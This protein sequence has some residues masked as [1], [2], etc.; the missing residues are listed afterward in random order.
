MI[1][2]VIVPLAICVKA[3][4]DVNAKKLLRERII[5]IMIL[6]LIVAIIATLIVG[7][8]VKTFFGD[9]CGFVAGIYVCILLKKWV[10][11]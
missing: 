8:V 11:N 6:K 10:E 3:L 9:V 5:V 7:C 4:R 1:K 2:A